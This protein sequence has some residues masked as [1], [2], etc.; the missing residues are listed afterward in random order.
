MADFLFYVLPNGI[1]ERAVRGETPLEYA[2]SDQFKGRGVRPGDTLW[3]VRCPEH[4]HLVLAGRIVVDQIT[5]RPTATEILG[6]PL[7]ERAASATEDGPSEFV[8]ARKGTYDRVRLKDI[9]EVAALLRFERGERSSSSRTHS[10]RLPRSFTG[11]HL[12]TLRILTVE[13]AL[14][15]ENLWERAR[16]E[17]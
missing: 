5:D 13:S 9:S 15:L 7:F 16:K 6:R 3:I 1:E 12:Q 2:A 10:D 11:Q 4:G 17:S 8:L 14:I